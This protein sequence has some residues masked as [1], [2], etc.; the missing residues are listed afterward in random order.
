MQTS[1]GIGVARSIGFALLVSG[2][3][4]AQGRPETSSTS[5]P[6]S[7]TP[8][9]ALSHFHFFGAR[10]GPLDGLASGM[11]VEE[12]WVR[13]PAL[14]D[15]FHIEVE[16]S[17]Y[18]ALRQR[19]PGIGEATSGGGNRFRK[20]ASRAG[21]PV[22]IDGATYEVRFDHLARLEVVRVRFPDEKTRTA[23]TAAWGP[24]TLKE[25]SVIWADEVHHIKAESTQCFADDVPRGCTVEFLPYQA[26][27]SAREQLW[28]GTTTLLGR[29]E[30][31]LPFGEGL[32]LDRFTR[33]H[34]AGDVCALLT[35]IEVQ[36][37]PDRRVV[38]Y[39]TQWA[40]TYAVSR[41]ETMWRALLDAVPDLKPD[42]TY[43]GFGERWVGSRDGARVEVLHPLPQTAFIITVG[44]WS[45]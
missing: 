34:V 39:R 14:R 26:L 37:G 17:A 28:P 16:V 42:E 38:A 2:A 25:R 10:S 3:L 30:A 31:S 33:Y 41:K 29:S 6:T 13:A 12:A 36:F 20:T 1:T 19:L 4:H 45:L 40:W 9:H 23:A 15:A 32:R 43:G 35:P 44:P 8:A 24:P 18:A 5:S 7:S 27:E 22:T 11:P 21:R